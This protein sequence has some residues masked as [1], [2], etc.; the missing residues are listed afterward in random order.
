MQASAST[1]DDLCNKK[2]CVHGKCFILKRWDHSDDGKWYAKD[3]QDWSK[4]N[5]DHSKPWHH[6]DWE[7]HCECD[8]KFWGKQLQL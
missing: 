2:A 7:A 8:D 5:D 4:W 6:P 1:E 3:W